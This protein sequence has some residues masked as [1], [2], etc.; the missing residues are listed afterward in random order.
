MELLDL[1]PAAVRMTGL[2]AGTPDDA[3]EAPT[4]CSQYR[5]GD[6]LD[7][8]AGLTTAFTEAATKTTPAGAGPPPEGDMA[9]LDAEWRRKVPLALADLVEAWHDP[10][11]YEGMTS[12]G[13]IE[14][15]G[16]IAAI[17]A[18]EELVVH[19]WDLARATGQP[20]DP[21]T[22][23]LDAVEGFL[24]QFSGPDQ[25]DLRGTAY[26][27]P[28]RLGV[29]APALDRVIGLSGRDPGWVRA[30]HP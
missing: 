14:M 23:E 4:P 20:F 22:A 11:A 13:G 16:E 26:A 5:V 18:L 1:N 30:G 21:S 9:N 7:H 29:E 3:L 24:S 6:L 8:I 19:G 10:A 27:A 17:V 12:A 2:L 15:P 28:V 25:A